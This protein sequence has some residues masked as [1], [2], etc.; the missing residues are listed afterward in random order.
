MSPS[1]AVGNS[2]FSVDLDVECDL[3]SRMGDLFELG[4]FAQLLSLKFSVT[5]I[6]R[7]SVRVRRR[8]THLSAAREP[9]PLKKIVGVNPI[10][11]QAV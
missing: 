10:F 9:S 3:S 6:K 4:L 11:L 8:T 7:S 1:N 2:A 5:V